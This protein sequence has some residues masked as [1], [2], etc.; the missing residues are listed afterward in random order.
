[1]N[2]RTRLILVN[3]PH[4]PSGAVFMRRR[5]GQDLADLTAGTDILVLSDEVYEHLVFEG[6]G[7]A[8]RAS[9]R[10]CRRAAS[11]CRRLAKPTTPRAGRWATA[12]PRPP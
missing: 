2:A 7:R 10:R 8:A 9:T 11:C 1:M 6:V 3:S 5:L 4:S 12:W